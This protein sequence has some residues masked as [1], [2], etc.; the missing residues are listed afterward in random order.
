[1]QEKFSES[2]I[3]YSSVSLN[4]IFG[5]KRVFLAGFS[6]TAFVILIGGILQEVPISG[7]QKLL[8]LLQSVRLA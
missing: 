8:S 4:L 6:L 5:D 3:Q 7:D 2:F 1:V